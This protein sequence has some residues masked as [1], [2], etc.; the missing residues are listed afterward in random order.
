MN[1]S[2]LSDAQ[3]LVAAKLMGDEAERRRLGI[4]PGTYSAEPVTV[5]VPGGNV[6]VN[7]DEFAA[8]TVSVSW[9]SVMCIALHRA[10]FQ[11]D[12]IMSLVMESVADSLGRGE[13]TAVQLAEIKVGEVTVEKAVKALQAKIRSE[14]PKQRKNGKTFVTVG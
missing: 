9:L 10:G 13:K 1:L 8:P 5:A 4:L 2:N 7:P 12:N 11:R 14:L 6:K 3:V